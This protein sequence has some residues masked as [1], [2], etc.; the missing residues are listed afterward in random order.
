MKQF[1]VAAGILMLSISVKGQLLLRQAD[2]IRIESQIPE[3]SYVI[4]TADH[5]LTTNT[6]GFHRSDVQNTTTKAKSTDYFHLGS[7]TKAITGFI[8]AY[9]VVQKKISWNT[10]F[11]DLFPEL[12]KDANAAYLDI[13]LADCLSHRARIKPYTSGTELVKLPKFTGTVSERR[14]QFVAYLVKD[15]P[16]QKTNAAYSYSN[17]GYSVAAAMLEKVSGRTWEKLVDDILS[18][19]LHLN[20]KFGWPNKTNT[21]QPWGHWIENGVLT[22]LPGTTA[23]N[24]NLIEPAGDLSM[25]IDDYAKFIQ[26]N[27]SGLNGKD[28]LLKSETYKYL[29]YGQNDYSIGWLNVNSKGKQISEHAGSAGTFYCYT[30]INTDKNIAYIIIANC[31]TENAQKGIFK[32]LNKMIQSKA[33]DY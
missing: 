11:F 10:R 16:V 4:L 28:N 32:L 12:K 20:Y 24:L 8:A 33:A 6:L 26:L 23:Y 15:E 19:K 17:A 13:T 30:L 3:L 9:L 31:A 14:S 27:L 25:P 21:I 29:H 1:C 22:P 5:I 2:S 7:N 18:K